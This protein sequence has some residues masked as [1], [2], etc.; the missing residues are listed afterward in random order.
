MQ[1]DFHYYATYCAAYLAGYSHEESQKIG[2]SSQF[3]DC[4]SATLL[5]KLHGPVIA[6]TTQLQLE[7]MNARTDFIGLQ[8]ITRIW[9]PFHFLPGN[10]YAKV[11]HGS[12]IYKNKYRLICDSNSTLVEDTVRLA[13]GQSLQAAGIAMHVLADT[14]AHRYFAGTPSL[15]I[16]NTDNGFFELEKKDGA[17]RE[18]P[19][20]FRHNPKK[21]DDMEENKFTNSIYQGNENSI[22]NLGHG[23]AGHLPDYSYICYKYLPAWGN[24]SAIIKENPKDYRLAFCQMIQALKFLRGIESEFKKN[25]YDFEA[26]SAYEDRIREILTKRQLIASEDWKAFGEAL[27]GKV[28]EDFDIDRYQEEYESAS[29]EEK[30]DTFLGEFFSS[31]I[32]HK[33]MVTGKIV[34]SGNL[35][36]G[37]ALEKGQEMKAI[38]DYLKLL[39]E[40]KRGKLT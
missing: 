25:T 19:I 10:L 17:V 24:Y 28:I 36:A 11:E 37:V 26:I 40:T 29:E 2:Y 15:V 18:I 6:A 7:M 13:K 1:L 21:A 20:D 12:M 9:A 23:R 33:S 38:R 4:C 8:D 5:K 14:W 16:N 34:A 39:K 22:M 35:L 27:S 32:R 30:D 31:A 3:V